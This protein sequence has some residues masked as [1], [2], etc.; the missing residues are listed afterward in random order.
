MPKKPRLTRFA[1]QRYVRINDSFDPTATVE[2]RTSTMKPILAGDFARTTVSPGTLTTINPNLKPTISQV[3][4]YANNK[5]STWQ[6]I[7]NTADDL[8]PYASNILNAFRKPIAPPMPAMDPGVTLQRVNLDNDR[9]MVERGIRGANMNADRT[10]DENTSQA[11]KQYN[12][13]TRFNQLSQVNQAERNANT[14]IANQE[15]QTNANITARNNMKTD[16]RGRDLVEMQVAN[17]REKSANIA[18]AADKYISIKNEK[19][20]ANLDMKKFGIITAAYNRDGVAGRQYKSLAE[21]IQDP[22][23]LEYLNN[24]ANEQGAAINEKAYNDYLER[25]KKASS[26]KKYGGVLKYSTGGMMK[27]IK[28]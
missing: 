5:T 4:T 6:K 18:N 28:P 9:A 20:K 1:K 27:I 19:A 15:T 14:E 3:P 16:Q 10:L 11:V 12:L 13:A 26:M 7:A 22:A 2:R 24:N 8:A 21:I 25:K 23:G 17:Q